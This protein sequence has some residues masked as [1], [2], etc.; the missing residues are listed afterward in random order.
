M[1][2]FAGSKRSPC[3]F[4]L[5]ELVLLRL[6]PYVQKLVVRRPCPKLAFKFFSLYNVVARIG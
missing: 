2:N 1:K 6:Q 3:E 5:G 4:Q